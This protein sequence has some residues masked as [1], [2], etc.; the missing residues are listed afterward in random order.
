MCK[1]SVPSYGFTWEVRANR[2]P[3]H[4]APR[5]AHLAAPSMPLVDLAH[6]LQAWQASPEKHKEMG[7]QGDKLPPVN[8]SAKASGSSVARCHPA[9]RVVPLIP[10]LSPLFSRVPLSSQPEH[11]S[12]P[13]HTFTFDVPC[14]LGTPPTPLMPGQERL[15]LPGPS[16][17]AKMR[18]KTVGG[19]PK[20]VSLPAYPCFL[21]PG[22]KGGMS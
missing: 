10:R 15:L 14:S 20:A 1:R 17:S 6:L 19:K 21:V 7:N 13:P 18:N 12:Q 8:P 2:A 5:L 11:D 9:W 4:P 22:S 16:D 3:P